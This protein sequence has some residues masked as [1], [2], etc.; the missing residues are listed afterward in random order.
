MDARMCADG[1]G[2]RAGLAGEK[3]R[4]GEKDWWALA[5]VDARTCAGGVGCKRKVGNGWGEGPVGMSAW[6]RGR[7]ADGVECGCN[8]KGWKWLGRRT[9]GHERAWMRCKGEVGAG[10]T[11]GHERAWMRGC[12]RTVWRQGKGWKW[13]GIR[14]G[15]NERGCAEVCG[16]CGR[17][18]KSGNGWGEGPVG[19][20][21]R[22]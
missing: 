14:T 19:M 2:A 9:G 13:V 16:K 17:K 15:G 21:E 8:E 12:V 11:G 6:M 10:P 7:V 5:S 3:D 4:C 22:G 1:V 20:S 18:G